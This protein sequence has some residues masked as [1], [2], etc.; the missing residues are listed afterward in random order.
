MHD[1]E[2]LP[3]VQGDPVR[4]SLP[5]WRKGNT[6]PGAPFSPILSTPRGESFPHVLSHW[7]LPEATSRASYRAPASADLPPR[8]SSSYFHPPL[9]W[10]RSTGQGLPTWPGCKAMSSMVHSCSSKCRLQ[11][12]R[13]TMP[14]HF[15]MPEASTITPSHAGAARKR[16]LD[17]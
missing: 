16:G 2:L 7:C 12:R 8:R 3:S 11:P 1:P 4:G 5:H 13:P 17:I 15:R 14:S 9:R 6:L 10:R